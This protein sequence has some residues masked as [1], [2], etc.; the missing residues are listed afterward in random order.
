MLL[1]FSPIS[2]TSAPP[3]SACRM[4]LIEWEARRRL[5]DGG[6]ALGLD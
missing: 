5:A 2:T 4:F 3:R 1:L 6:Q